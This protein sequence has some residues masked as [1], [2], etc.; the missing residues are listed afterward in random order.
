VRYIAGDLC[1]KM[2]RRAERRARKRSLNQVE[3]VAADMTELPIASGEAGLFLSYSGLHMVDEPERAVAEIARCL[4]PDGR[5]A[6]R[7]SAA[8]PERTAFESM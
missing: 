4:K 8:T 6:L 1:P 7:S 3:F 5:L 2:L